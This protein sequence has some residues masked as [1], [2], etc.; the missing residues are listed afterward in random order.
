MTKDYNQYHHRCCRCVVSVSASD[1]P[2]IDQSFDPSP[3]MIIWPIDVPISDQ[4]LK[5]DLNIVHEISLDE[6]DACEILT[7]PP[8]PTISG[9]TVNPAIFFRGASIRIMSTNNDF[10]TWF[11]QQQHL[12]YITSNKSIDISNIDFNE[13]PTQASS[14]TFNF[15]EEQ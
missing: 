14:L 5:Y 6:L 3:I 11:Q 4:I 8:T 9:L 7:T 15:V 2:I 1:G 12:E 10:I 13:N